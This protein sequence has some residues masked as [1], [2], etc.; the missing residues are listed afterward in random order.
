M[1]RSSLVVLLVTVSG[2]SAAE[3]SPL[4]RKVD[5]FTLKDYRGKEHSLDGLKDSKLVVLAF[6]G[7]ECPLAKL[8]APR[9][10]ALEK[11][12]GPKGVAF[13]GLNANSQDGVV[14]IAAHARAHKIDFPVL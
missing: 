7:T 3:P 13:L 8:Y 1:L 9:L 4:G 6:L 2:A 11:E 14:A 5:N 10:A 12:F